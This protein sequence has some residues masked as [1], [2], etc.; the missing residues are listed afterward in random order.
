MINVLMN[1]LMV[2]VH[3]YID[4]W[5]LLCTFLRPQRDFRTLMMLSLSRGLEQW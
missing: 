3:L 4:L 2:N 1:V 5:I